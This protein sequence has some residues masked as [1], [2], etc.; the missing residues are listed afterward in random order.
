V[1]VSG[2]EASVWEEGVCGSQGSYGEII[3]DRRISNRCD[4]QT[5]ENTHMSKVGRRERKKCATLH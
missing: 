3:H 2:V 5:E 4:S 1:S